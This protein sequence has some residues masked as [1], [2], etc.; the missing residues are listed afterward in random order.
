MHT[1]DVVVWPGTLSDGSTC[2]AAWCTYVAGV[3][4]QGDTEE[5]ALAEI[6][7]MIEDVVN[8]PEDAAES[9]VDY[10]TAAAKMADLMQELKDDGTACWVRSVSVAVSEPTG[11]DAAIA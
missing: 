10:E 2:Y 4:G 6:A 8:D 1:F 11:G 7:G 5:A 3:W 9:M